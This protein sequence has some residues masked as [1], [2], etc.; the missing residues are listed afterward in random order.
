MSDVAVAHRAHHRRYLW[1][2]RQAYALVN[3]YFTWI[4]LIGVLLAVAGVFN[5]GYTEGVA[6]AGGGLSGA[7]VLTGE[8]VRNALVLGA[9]YALVAVGYTMVYGIIELIN[10]AHGD[11][12]TLSAFYAL[13][14]DRMLGMTKWAASGAAGLAAALGVT[15]L[16][17]TLAAGLTGVVIEFV[18]YRPLRHKP[19]LTA[20]ITAIGMSFL[21]EG[22]I[23]AFWGVP[24]VPTHKEG[25]V[26]GIAFA[27]SGVDISWHAVAV[28]GTAVIAM[29]AL[30]AF[31]RRTNLGRAM[32]ATA[33]D[34]DAAE[35]S[36]INVNK[37][38]SIT[39]F[40]GSALAGAAAIIY[41]INYGSIQWQLGFHLGIIAFTA[42]VLGGIGNITGAG[43][44]AFLIGAIYVL[45]G[46][47]IPNGGEWSESLIFAMLVIILTFRPTGILGAAVSERA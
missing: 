31:V 22:L 39:F 15:L 7:W 5:K 35:L 19:R 23:Q 27:L 24:N 41:S 6:H 12:F 42:A 11:V 14:F 29:V 47:L 40:I 13:Q 1:Y 37:T 43:L 32:R 25:W 21:L 16:L 30:Q 45:G 33:Q 9:I 3:R 18:A 26:S 28:V 20:L 2:G 44:G 4:L 46:E 34:R 38:I 36:G 8:T 10:F 17:T